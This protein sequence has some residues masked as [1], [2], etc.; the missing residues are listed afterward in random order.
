MN[1]GNSFGIFVILL[2]L[3]LGY[4]IPAAVLT[5][6]DEGLIQEEKAIAIEKIELFTSKADV[7]EQLGIFEE[8]MFNH[9]VIETDEEKEYESVQQADK[10]NQN[11][12]SNLEA[13]VQEFWQVLKKESLEMEKFVFAN[14]IMMAGMNSNS[15]Y[16]IWE[17]AGAGKDGETYYF[18]IDDTTGKVIGFDVP[19]ASVGDTDGEFYAVMGRL[20]EYYGFFAY[21]FNDM[22]RDL[23]KIKYWQ[24]GLNLCD[25]YL[26][27][28]LSLNIYKSGDRLQFN[29]YPNTKSLSESR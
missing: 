5:V 3:C 2:L 20:S 15:L 26:A 28:K 17:C 7:V 16:S 9:I 8:M 6:E 1:R 11:D 19:Y 14:Y 23:S 10:E 24:N 18:W 25:E 27:V 12:E 13:C 4:F 22:L 21:E 29:H